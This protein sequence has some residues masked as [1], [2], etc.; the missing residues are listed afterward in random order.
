MSKD[1]K[2]L[3]FTVVLRIRDVYPGSMIPELIF[4]IPDPGSRVDKIP[5]RIKVLLTQKTDT[6]F[7]III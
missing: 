4:P 7:S 2:H 6:T 1:E 3:V 5:I